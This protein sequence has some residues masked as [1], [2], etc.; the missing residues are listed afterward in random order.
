MFETYC[1]AFS[2]NGF[3]N[4][5]EE[6][7]QHVEVTN[8]SRDNNKALQQALKKLLDFAARI[9]QSDVDFKLA[10]RLKIKSAWLNKTKSRVRVTNK[11]LAEAL[12]TI[13]TPKPAPTPPPQKPQPRPQPT[14]PPTRPPQRPR[15]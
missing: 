14:Q 7:R 12:M 8:L 10:S 2:I 11:E 9:V 4:R 3:D 13:M 6:H 1:F 5:G 15:R